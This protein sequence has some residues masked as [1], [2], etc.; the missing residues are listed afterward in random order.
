MPI[1]PSIQRLEAT[2]PKI[3]NAIRNDLGGTYA[4]LIPLA[5]DTNE[6]IR[7]IGKVVMENPLLQNS[8]L[9]ALMNRIGMTII[10][11]KSYTNPWNMFKRGLLDMGE[12]IEEIFVSIAEPYQFDPDDAED[13]LF[14]Q[15]KPDVNT[16]F[17]TLN[18][19]KFYP[20]TI[21]ENE[22]R[23]A[24]LTMSG[25]TDL[26]SKETESM[27]NGM[28]YDEFIVMKYLL[29]RTALNGL[30]NP[31]TIPAITKENL[32]DIVTQIKTISNNF[33]YMSNLYNMAGVQTFSEIADQYIIINSAFDS[34][35][36]VELLSVAFN[37]DKAD[38]LG[39]K[40]GVDSFAQVDTARLAKL[41]AGDKAYTPFTADELTQLATLPAIIVD[42]DFFMI[43][44]N[45]QEMTSVQNAKGLYWNYFL[46][47]WK[48]FSVSPF[49]NAVLFT[50]LTPSITAV[51]VSP[52]TASAGKGTRL[53][54]LANIDALGF[55]NDSVIW[56]VN[57]DKSVVTPDGQL[58]IG[59]DEVAA[60]ITVTA[61]SKFDATKKD[62]S[63]ITIV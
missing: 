10:T 36:S 39:H 43:F 49:A 59:A 8:F 7:A 29:A 16:A 51:T 58:T 30:I 53:L 32:P 25:V 11:S 17:H 24:F 6:S 5:N 23:Q 57:S 46:H 48:T 50:T 60:T 19:S 45:L 14:K 28:Q 40:V 21:R 42:K 9:S 34:R 15:Y 35:T 61:T 20:V 31:V 18:F 37:M 41:F 63:V 2:T 52:S 22:L 1:R 44:D 54:L 3:L 47:V 62:T 55:A 56:S 26:I 38:F 4:D 33:K 27:Y 12:T 13:T